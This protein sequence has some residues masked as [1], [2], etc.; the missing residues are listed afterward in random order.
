MKLK[1][2]TGEVPPLT[3]TS[4]LAIIFCLCEILAFRLVVAV[5]SL[6]A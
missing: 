3:G 2:R 5:D 4:S 6:I 1:K